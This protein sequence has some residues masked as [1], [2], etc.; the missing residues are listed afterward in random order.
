MVDQRGADDGIHRGER[1][2]RE[3]AERGRHLA[4]EDVQHRMF[5]NLVENDVSTLE[6]EV[7][8]PFVVQRCRR[9]RDALT[10]LGI[11][12]NPRSD[13]T[14]GALALEAPS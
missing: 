9:R 12:E 8:E 7:L 1:P 6:V 2:R 13:E 4:G 3:A 10:Y 11:G 5:A 14:V